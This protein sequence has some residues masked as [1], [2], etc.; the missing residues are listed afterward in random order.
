MNDFTAHNSSD[1]NNAQFLAPETHQRA[2]GEGKG[3]PVRMTIAQIRSVVDA[4]NWTRN[5]LFG[6]TPEEFKRMDVAA[7]LGPRIADCQALQIPPRFAKDIENRA[8]AIERAE[9]MVVRWRALQPTA[10]PAS[11]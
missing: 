1:T 5:D 6:A 4:L 11:R 3:G 2:E 10:T 8:F 9:A 7:H